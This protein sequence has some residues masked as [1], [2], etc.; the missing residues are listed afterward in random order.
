MII[1]DKLVVKDTS[2]IDVYFDTKRFFFDTSE[3]IDAVDCLF[4]LNKLE[5]IE[6]LG[7]LRY[8]G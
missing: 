5:Y 6:D 1:L 2:L 3:F 7:V 4:A 8:V